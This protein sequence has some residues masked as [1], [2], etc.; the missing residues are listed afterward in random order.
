MLGESVLKG[1][2]LQICRQME[3]RSNLLLHRTPMA[4]SHFGHLKL[5][6]PDILER[7]ENV[8]LFSHE[9]V[10]TVMETTYN[11]IYCVVIDQYTSINFH[12][13]LELTG[14]FRCVP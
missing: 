10:S 5:I 11:N 14:Y 7:K 9:L 1:H 12:W 4:G 6:F 3:V 2:G 8:R 13:E